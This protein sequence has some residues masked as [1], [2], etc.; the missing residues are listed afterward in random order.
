VVA[1]ALSRLDVD[2][3]SSLSVE[4]S[5]MAEVFVSEGIP[6]LPILYN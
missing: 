6:L 5:A 1:D 2:F 4:E 3:S